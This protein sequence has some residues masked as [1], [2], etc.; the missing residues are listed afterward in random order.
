[1]T[2]TRF[3][4]I[5]LPAIAIPALVVLLLP[6]N[7]MTMY[8]DI[9]EPV[10][11]L[12][13]SYLAL[14]VS[15]SYRKQLKAAF[16][17]LSL[18]LLIYAL[19]VI[20]FLSNTPLLIP[21]L[22]SRLENA[23]I[24]QIVQG[25][26]FVVYAMLLFFCINLLRVIDVTRLNRS[27]LV[28]LV[29]TAVFCL[30]LALY[31]VADLLK[32]SPSLELSG[33][34]QI[35]IRVLDALLIIVLAPVLWLYIQYL[36]SQQRQSLTFTVIIL[37]IVCATIFDYIFQLITTLFPGMLSEGS[38][39]YTTIP[40]VL[41]IYGYLIIAVGLYAHRKQDEW[42][43]QTVDRIMSGELALLGEE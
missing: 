42:G 3:L 33:I 14:W 34:F 11:L 7:A 23:E 38:L 27:G 8:V 21:A 20:L 26:Q 40:E 13:G 16:I 37:G 35:T 36:K 18:F 30:L 1:M 10:A 5:A 41:F 29:L 17:F 9:L 25:V 43:Y 32:N 31:P 4:K 19:A 2:H 12:L 28:L 22:E 6:E 15:F 39:L 24:L